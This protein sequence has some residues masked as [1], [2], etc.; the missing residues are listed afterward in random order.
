MTG[1]TKAEGLM[2]MSVRLGGGCAVRGRKDAGKNNLIA[3]CARS[4]CAYDNTA[5][6]P[7]VRQTLQHWGY[8]L[9]LEDFQAEAKRFKIV[10]NGI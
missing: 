6:S 4:G 3:K 5:I 8:R 1:F 10:I 7:V 9:T 2:T